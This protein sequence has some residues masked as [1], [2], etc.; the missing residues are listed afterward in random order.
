MD[1]NEARVEITSFLRVPTSNS[2]CYE[3]LRLAT[4]ADGFA[5]FMHFYVFIL[6]FSE[7]I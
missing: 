4:L 7:L 6:Y 5:F 3:F 2:V 1:F